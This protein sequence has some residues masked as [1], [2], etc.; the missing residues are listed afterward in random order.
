MKVPDVSQIDKGVIELE[1]YAENRKESDQKSR[2][3][4]KPR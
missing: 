3:E 2:D 1:V 4:I